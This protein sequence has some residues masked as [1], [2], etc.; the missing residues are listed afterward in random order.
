MMV[1]KRTSSGLGY[2]EW[3]YFVQMANGHW[4]CVELEGVQTD[5]LFDCWVVGE[6]YTGDE[7]QS[8]D[9]EEAPDYVIEDCPLF[10]VLKYA[11]RLVRSSARLSNALDRS[12]LELPTRVSSAKRIMDAD[13]VG[14]ARG[15]SNG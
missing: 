6:V 4:L 2:M 5:G 1:V 8:G 12:G 10:G 9:L 15:K 11:E 13:I 3:A 14:I 7:I